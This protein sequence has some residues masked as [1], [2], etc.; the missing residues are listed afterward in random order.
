MS[1]KLKADEI[2]TISQEKYRF[3]V[4]GKQWQNVEEMLQV[5]YL[6]HNHVFCCSPTIRLVLTM[7][8][9]VIPNFTRPVKLISLNLTSSSRELFV[10]SLGKSLKSTLVLLLLP[11]SG[12][13]GVC[14]AVT[15]PSRPVKIQSSK[16]LLPTKSLK[17]L[18]SLLL[19]STISLKLNNLKLSTILLIC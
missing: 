13:T 10:H 2:R 7:P 14:T 19:R 16:L 1:Y 6:Y 5:S 4:N 15:C 9:L 12:D 11:S 3:S 18:V 17:S 8:L